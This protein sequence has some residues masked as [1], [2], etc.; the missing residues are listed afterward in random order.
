MFKNRFGQIVYSAAGDGGEGGG[1]GGGNGEQD[2][3]G[4]VAFQRAMQGHKDNVEGFARTL[5]DDNYKLR[6]TNST[7]R[8]QTA[9]AGAIILQ[10]DDAVAWNAYKTLGKHTELV[11]VSTVDPL[12]ADL[13]T[14]QTTLA[15][16]QAELA[17]LKRSA[18]LR[19][20][21]ETGGMVYSVLATLDKPNLSYEIT[22]GKDKDDKPVKVV[23]VKDGDKDVVDLDT[24]AAANWSVF[25]ASLR[26]AQSNGTPFP[27]QAGTSRTTTST[28]AQAA[29]G[30]LDQRY[31]KKKTA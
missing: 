1:N 11:P 14:A 7:L 12:K 20:V 21:A 13:T 22:D 25:A 15:T 3:G 16:T 30:A 18:L 5:Y 29:S 17:T 28:V 6:Q 24:Y 8:S 9:P 4:A 2:D 31:G 27:I 19:D 10:G 23:K 26:P